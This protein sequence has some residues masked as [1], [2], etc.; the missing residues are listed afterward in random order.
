LTE[1][2]RED[3]KAQLFERLI[4]KSIGNLK[5]C[6]L[7]PRVSTTDSTSIF[8]EM[9][10]CYNTAMKSVATVD[11]LKLL[12][13]KRTEC[14]P[15]FIGID[16]TPGQRSNLLK[17]IRTKL[18]AAYSTAENAAKTIA[19]LALYN[20]GV[21]YAKLHYNSYRLDTRPEKTYFATTHNPLSITVSTAETPS[22]SAGSADKPSKPVEPDPCIRVNPFGIAEVNSGK[23]LNSDLLKAMELKSDFVP[24]NL[25]RPK[26]STAKKTHEPPQTAPPK[27]PSKSAKKEG[28]PR[29]H[30]PKH[31]PKK[32]K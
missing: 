32:Q 6:F 3:L 1:A 31:T 24:Q 5:T 7:D 26:S 15:K 10:A 20:N 25:T 12:V 29:K 30:R 13:S 14:Q 28:T 21:A 8:V 9:A 2:C 27:Q 11:S 4:H 19:Y 17:A 23:V 22:A 18:G 16:R